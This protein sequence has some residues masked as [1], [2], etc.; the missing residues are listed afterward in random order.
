[1]FQLHVQ[2]SCRTKLFSRT[3]VL[4]EGDEAGPNR[5]VGAFDMATPGTLPKLN[6][7]AVMVSFSSFHLFINF[8]TVLNS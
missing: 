6:K 4:R 2:L 1:M 8:W 7:K 5:L 3:P